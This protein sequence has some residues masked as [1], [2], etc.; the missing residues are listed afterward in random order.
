MRAQ[1]PY[2][3]QFMEHLQVDLTHAKTAIQELRSALKTQGAQLQPVGLKAAIAQALEMAGLP[4][5]IQ[6]QLRLADDTLRVMANDR[7]ANVFWNLFDNARKAMPQ[8]GYLHVSAEPATDAGWVWVRV[9]DSG[10]GIQ[11]WRLDLIFEPEE[12]T[13][14]DPYAPAHGLGLWWTRAQVESFGGS[15]S[16]E[17]QEGAGTCVTLKLRRA[18]G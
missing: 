18:F 16:V 7:L 5:T 2:L 6:K 10:R 13:P 4:D 9:Q 1:Y 15:I 14:G 3:D 8:G 11:P 12:T 17:S